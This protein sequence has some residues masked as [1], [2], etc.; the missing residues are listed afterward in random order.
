MSWRLFI[1]TLTCTWTSTWGRQSQHGKT[2]A[3]N[4]SRLLFTDSR[5]SAICCSDA[6]N[7][8]HDIF[9]LHDFTTFTKQI[10]WMR[11]ILSLDIVHMGVHVTTRYHMQ[12]VLYEV[13][14]TVF[15]RLSFFCNWL[16]ILIHNFKTA[17]LRQNETVS[18]C[19]T[20]KKEE[21]KMQPLYYSQ[22]KEAPEE[23]KSPTEDN[24][25]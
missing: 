17:N 7:D 23:T 15:I 6:S 12:F 1:C 20:G 8:Q 16:Y 13:Y 2:R 10:V 25:G 18:A 24:I 11:F 19:S 21:R 14:C 9:H 22:V 5:L 3:F 4:F